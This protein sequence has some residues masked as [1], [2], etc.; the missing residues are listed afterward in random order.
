MSPEG[1][2]PKVTRA[3]L[4]HFDGEATRLILW[5]QE[6]GARIRISKRGHALVYGPNGGSAAISPKSKGHNRSSH[7]TKS[8]V[9]RLFKKGTGE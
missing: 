2:A 4:R 5:A 9:S 6:Q 1:D 3:D 7:N 8:E